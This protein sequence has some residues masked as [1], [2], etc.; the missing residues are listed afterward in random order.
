MM[1]VY[2]ADMTELHP[3]QMYKNATVTGNCILGMC[4][5]LKN[6]MYK[7]NFQIAQQKAN[8]CPQT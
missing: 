8:L 2:V 7:S 3:C 4:P 1:I 5:Q 6:L